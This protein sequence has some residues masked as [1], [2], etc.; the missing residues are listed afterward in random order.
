MTLLLALLAC[1]PPIVVYDTGGL[2]G[3]DSTIESNADSGDT[4]PQ[5]NDHDGYTDDVDCDDDNA[6]VNPGRDEI[7]YDGTDQDCDGNDMDQDLDGYRSERWDP[8]GDDCDDD[9]HLVFPDAEESWYDG[10]DQDCDFVCDYDADNDGE[11]L[12]KDQTTTGEYENETYKSQG[13]DPCEDFEDID[14][15]DQDATINQDGIEVVDGLDNDCDGSADGDWTL[16]DDAV[17]LRASTTG[18]LGFRLL[19][20]EIDTDAGAEVYATMPSYDGL[21]SDGGYLVRW[22]SAD[23]AGRPGGSLGLNEG[24]FA[25]QPSSANLR[26]GSSLLVDDLDEDGQTELA[27]GVPGARAVWLL[28]NSSI[29][30]GSSD[31]PEG[32]LISS[33]AVDGDLAVFDGQ[34]AVGSASGSGDQGTVHFLQLTASSWG[35]DITIEDNYT[36]KV[37]DSSSGADGLGVSMVVLDVNTDGLDD[38][39]IGAPDDDVS[40]ADGGAIYVVDGG[41]FGASSVVDVDDLASVKGDKSGWRFGQHLDVVED[42]DGDGSFDLAVSSEDSSTTRVHL[43]PT[44]G[45][46]FSKPA[47]LIDDRIELARTDSRDWDLVGSGD[48]D[49]DGHGDVVVGDPDA[50][51]VYVFFGAGLSSRSTTLIGDAEATV[52]G[53]AGF[54]ASA[55]VGDVDGDGVIDIVASSPTDGRLV[56]MPTAF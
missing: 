16:L 48:V 38:L 5:D 37:R 31:V 24:G 36:V 2:G 11:G 45:T 44:D 47:T 1:P 28:D 35:P 30:S 3:D 39:V 9:D 56:V 23:I 27:V 33:L 25:V 46:F 50:Q 13:I 51:E 29:H 52:T 21:F 49:G 53:G 6:A 26:L 40:K 10:I 19:L 20:E 22:D 43:M 34:I 4:Q 18:D 32:K 17:E 42:Y 8:T 15:D 14:C 54:G 12:P 7:W 41:T 55:A